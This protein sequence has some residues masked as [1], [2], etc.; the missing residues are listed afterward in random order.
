MKQ[1]FLFIGDIHGEIKT[2]EHVPYF[3]SKHGFNVSDIEQ[4]WQLG[5][6][7]I[8]ESV[9]LTELLKLS[10]KPKNGFHFVRGNHEQYEINGEDY[11]DKI[12]TNLSHKDNYPIYEHDGDLVILTKNHKAVCF[13]GALS[14]DARYRTAGIDYFPNRENVSKEFIDIQLNS[15]EQKYNIVISHDF[16]SS[17]G[18][19]FLKKMNRSSWG[20]LM[21]GNDLLDKIYHNHPPKLWIHGHHHATYIGKS[22]RTG[23]MFIG[24]DSFH[25][26]FDMAILE[27]DGSNTNITVINKYG[28]KIKD[29][30]NF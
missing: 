28:I 23:T 15:L 1:Q 21:P 24:I 22:E 30:I 25:D 29:S 14:I 6:L 8:W 9:D 26:N 18:A 2:L 11:F 19:S 13:G 7:G 20:F 4:I 17:W 27:I 12:V 10:K 5:D 16:P 3:L